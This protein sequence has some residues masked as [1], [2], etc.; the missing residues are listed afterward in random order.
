MKFKDIKEFSDKI[1]YAHMLA[2]HD[3]VWC[4]DQGVMNWVG[5]VRD[6]D[7]MEVYS[8]EMTEGSQRIEDYFIANGDTQQ[9]YWQT[10]IFPLSKEISCEEFEETY[11]E[12]M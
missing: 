12:G 3:S 10:F 7:G 9:G 2:P 8:A 11:G 5:D 1:N 4:V 6:S